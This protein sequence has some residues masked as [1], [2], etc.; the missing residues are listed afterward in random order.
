MNDSPS[1][2]NAVII[3]GHQP[4]V[5]EY[6]L[7]SGIAPAGTT[8]LDRLT[9]TEA[10]DK[11]IYGLVPLPLASQAQSVIVLHLVLPQSLRRPGYMLTVEEV[12]RYARSVTRYITRQDTGYVSPRVKDKRDLK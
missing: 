11:D 12:A 1:E 10:K 6:F 8:V 5:A 9:W 3:S 4:A 7:R 2:G